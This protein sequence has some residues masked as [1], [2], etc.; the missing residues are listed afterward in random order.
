[1]N[2][3]GVI[4]LWVLAVGWHLLNTLGERGLSLSKAVGFDRLN[5]RHRT[6]LR[7]Y[8]G[9]LLSVEGINKSNPIY[10]MRIEKRQVCKNGMNEGDERQLSCR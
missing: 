8:V 9:C 5:Q 4:C 1:M 10:L 3:K 2:S 7:R 6:L